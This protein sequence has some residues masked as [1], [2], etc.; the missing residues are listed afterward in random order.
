MLRHG[1]M[2]PFPTPI[3]ELRQ[4]NTVDTAKKR[5]RKAALLLHPNKGG[6]KTW[7]QKMMNEYHAFLEFKKR[8]TTSRPSTSR[9]S[10]TP[11]TNTNTSYPVTLHVEPGY[12]FRI[13]LNSSHTIR[14]VF[15]KV[16]D[17][18]VQHEIYDVFRGMYVK[19][20]CLR[21]PSNQRPNMNRV[22]N[23]KDFFKPVET[24]LKNVFPFNARARCQMEVMVMISPK[25]RLP[26][27]KIF[28]VP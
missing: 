15:Q 20:V 24:Q 5:M 23:K 27:N 14:D 7:F 18:A 8:N 16:V 22:L 21:Q 28:Y 17:Y 26:N 6:S 25:Q 9:P 11:R 19:V 13:R 1:T 3:L 10:P 4:N 2:N 12:D